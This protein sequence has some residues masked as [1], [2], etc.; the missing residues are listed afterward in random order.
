VKN[1]NTNQQKQ[2]K[3]LTWITQH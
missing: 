1:D 2:T 3:R